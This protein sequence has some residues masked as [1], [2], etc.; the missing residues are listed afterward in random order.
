MSNFT[1]LIDGQRY[2]GWETIRI[3]RG[4]EHASADFALSV[5]SRDP[6]P[7]YTGKSCEV[8]IDNDL[9]LTG[10]VDAYRPGCSESDHTIEITGRSKTCDFVDS[11]VT[12]D[13]GQF[14]GQTLAAVAKTLAQPFNLEVVAEKEGDPVPE[15]QVQQGE[16]C[17]QLIER[18]ARLQELLVTDDPQGRI[19]L[20][21]AGRDK[22]DDK[23][24]FGQN[25]MGASADMDDSQRFSDYIIK[26]Q[27]P[28]NRTADDHWTDIK[29]IARIFN[30]NTPDHWR[31]AWRQR[32]RLLREDAQ[33]RAD[34]RRPRLALRGD[35][36]FDPDS[37]YDDDEPGG[38]SDTDSDKGA[39][40]ITEIIGTAKDPGV[41]RYRPKVIV[42]EAQ[43]DDAVA[44]NRADWELRRRIA[45]AL[46]ST[47][48]LAGWRQSSGKLWAT[49]EMVYVK[50]PWLGLDRQMLI[51]E[52]EFS[53]AEQGEIATLNLV[54]PDAYLPEKFR[55]TKGKKK[56]TGT[57]KADSKWSDVVGL[58]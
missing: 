21:R 15:V 32:M 35:E 28:G 1:L 55:K 4:L 10:W 30:A 19:V 17:F 54:L 40:V 8:H 46:K 51:G 48:T 52:V 36:P 57:S 26:A 16:T 44:D 22:A 53:I 9:M 20:T 31:A 18:L 24:I 42:A 43:S 37:E 7:I 25:V 50:I 12:M 11:S 38:G 56:G 2:G 3:T 58:P 14:T 5:S 47:V 29:G 45:N 13:G 27:R 34:P 49:N 6:W 41:T 39:S 33:R 23:L